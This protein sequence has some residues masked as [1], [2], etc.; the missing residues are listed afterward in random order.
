VAVRSPA[1]VA[2]SAFQIMFSG[3]GE[4]APLVCS[5]AA[6]QVADMEAGFAAMTGTGAEVDISGLTFT[7]QNESGNNAEVVVA[8]TIKLTIAGT[9]TENPFPETTIPM[10]NENGWKICG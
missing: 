8:G 6:D 9:E 7:T 3:E 5:A 4:I 10:V 1:D 2:R